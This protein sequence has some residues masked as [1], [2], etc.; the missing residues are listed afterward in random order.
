MKCAVASL[1]IFLTAC[2]SRPASLAGTW[3]ATLASPG[4]EL[5]FTLRI[6][7][8]NAVIVNGAEQVPV[9][10]VDINGSHVTIRFDWYDS[11][12][13][14]DLSNDGNSMTGAWTRTVPAG[15]ARL[16]FRA[17]RG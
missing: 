10:G 8:K 4:G 13:N 7:Q 17:T 2:H 14:A 15:T 16:A 5:P 9:S 3:R 6:D 12:I 11:A 1:I